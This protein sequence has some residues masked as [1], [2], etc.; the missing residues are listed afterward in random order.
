MYMFILNT[1]H[2]AAVGVE[3]LIEHMLKYNAYDS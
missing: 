2:I 3:H 1:E